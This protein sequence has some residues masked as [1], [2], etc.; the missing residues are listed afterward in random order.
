MS[1]LK[2][3]QFS[4]LHSGVQVPRKILSQMGL[5]EQGL[6]ISNGIFEGSLFMEQLLTA[7]LNLLSLSS[8]TSGTLLLPILLA[9][10]R[11]LCGFSLLNL[12]DSNIGSSFLF[13]FPL[14]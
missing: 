3:W 1:E 10:H 6:G 9:R 8:F 11:R 5:P 4:P 12:G 7:S 13:L 14:F 2:L